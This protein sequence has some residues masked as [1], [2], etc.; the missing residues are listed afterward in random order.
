VAC[1]TVLSAAL[2]LFPLLAGRASGQAGAGERGIVV[3]EV[4]VTAE[5]IQEFV[6]NHPQEAVSV[7][8]DEIVQRNL[9]SVEDV[10]KTMPGVEVAASSGAG[11]R[12]SIRGSGKSGG[13][14][15]LVNGRPLNSNQYGSLDLNAIPVDLIESIT[16]FKPPVP[17]WLGPGGSEGAV[18]IVTR[19]TPSKEEKQ[20]WKNTVKPGAGSFG[21][22]E[23]ALTSQFTT[24]A[25]GALVSATTKHTDGRRKNSD[26]TD[27]ALGLN[28]SRDAGS[29][30]RYEMNGRWY[31]AEYGMPGPIDNLTPD[32]RQEYRKTS[33]D[34]SYKG[35][36]GAGGTY[37]FS[38]YADS[39][40]LR[41]RSQ[42]GAVYRLRDNKGGM[43][44]DY[45]WSKDE[46]GPE[47]RLGG[48][49]E[50]DRFDH[51]LAGEHHR[52]RNGL[53]AQYDQ[54]FGSWTTTAG[55]RGDYTNDFGSRPGATIGLGWGAGEQVLLRMRAGYTVNV[56]TF[57]QLYQTSHGSVDQTRGNPEL[58]EEKIRSCSAGV[59][60]TFAKDRFVH[61]T[62]FRNETDGLIGHE[63]GAD[64]IYR[65]VNIP[66]ATRQGVE[67][68]AKYAW[69]NGFAAELNVILQKSN[70]SE[71]NGDLPYT[72]RMKAKAGVQYAAPSLKTRFEFNARYE[73]T[74]YNQI[75][76]LPSQKMQEYITADLKATRPFSLGGK[77]G[78]AYARFDNLF[79][80]KFQAH[81]GYPDDGFRFVVGMQMKF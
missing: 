33:L 79:D 63:R 14:L 5:R 77:S 61:M 42:A 24:T 30:G 52:F 51:T 7:G 75:E 43:K 49:S 25:T 48:L 34:A 65:P 41:D 36:S 39:V 26:K 13:V 6:R 15:V 66:R 28:I 9:S 11:S 19:S 17:V 69:K 76:N 45:S 20:K 44:L 23:G 27:G 74:R 64:L 2:A 3:N 67:T 72:P 37:T 57:E 35:A 54:R 38:P 4:V 31:Q 32:A 62:L 16:V 55:V 1:R 21:Y 70:N 29:G 58:K 50:Y 78:D 22:I 53:S 47:F 10:L 18:N 59:E 73:G 56:P 68:T 81:L 60:Y 12:V 8:R 46:N 40:E 80:R 71:T